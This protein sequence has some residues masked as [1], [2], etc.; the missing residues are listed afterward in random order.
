MD[1]CQLDMQIW[2][3]SAFAENESGSSVTCR[4][5][6]FWICL[7]VG[8]DTILEGLQMSLQSSRNSPTIATKLVMSHVR[9]S[10]CM[11]P[12]I[13]FFSL[14]RKLPEKYW[15]Q[16]VSPWCWRP[17]GMNGDF[18]ASVA[19]AIDI[20]PFK[21]KDCAFCKEGMMFSIAIWDS[22]PI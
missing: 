22:L 8:D 19:L 18:S 1:W 2:Y 16:D 20:L 10:T 13:R 9:I 5:C 14:N 11:I 6:D 17:F 12:A 3:R 15:T 7:L 21:G 4:S